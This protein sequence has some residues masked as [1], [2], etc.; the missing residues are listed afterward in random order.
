MATSKIQADRKLIDQ[1]LKLHPGWRL[2]LAGMGF[3]EYYFR[4]ERGNEI[5][6]QPHEMQD[7][8]LAADQQEGRKRGKRS[9]I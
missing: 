7:E 6:R 4:D 9:H 2:R 1:Y 3:H 8:L 5:K